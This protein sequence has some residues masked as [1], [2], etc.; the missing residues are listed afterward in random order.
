MVCEAK[1]VVVHHA[2]T[3]IVQ[4]KGGW[5]YFFSTYSPCKSPCFNCLQRFLGIDLTVQ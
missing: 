2:Y 4:E 5:Q 3:F 1:D